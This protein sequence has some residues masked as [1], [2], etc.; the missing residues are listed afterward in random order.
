M[1]YSLG[2]LG[3]VAVILAIVLPLTLK[4]KDPDPIR[5]DPIGPN[6]LPAGIMNPY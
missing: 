2:A 5:P 4:R 3:V 1:Y 6:P